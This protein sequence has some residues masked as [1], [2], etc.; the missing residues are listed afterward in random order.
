MANLV[1]LIRNS[2]N[3][4]YVGI[5]TNIRRRLREHRDGDTPSTASGERDW[6]LV[7]KWKTK[8]HKHMTRLELYL[9]TIQRAMGDGGLM[10]F[11][12]RYPT[13]TPEL[14]SILDAM[15]PQYADYKDLTFPW[16]QFLSVD[17]TVQAKHHKQISKA[18]ARRNRN[19]ALPTESHNDA[20][21][22]SLAETDLAEELRVRAHKAAWYRIA[23]SKRIDEAN[24]H[25]RKSEIRAK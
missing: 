21:A 5:T 13:F 23:A 8:S 2:D 16:C 11:V 22:S 4:L 15:P 7:N 6:L 10:A 18:R 25:K 12:N 17:Q 3:V 19:I 20:P 9:Q 14:A 24:A 1:Y